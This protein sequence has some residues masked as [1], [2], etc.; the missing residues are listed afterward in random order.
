[1]LS[2]ASLALHVRTEGLTAEDV[3]GARIRDRSIVLTW[4]MRGT[5][6]LITAEDHGWLV[7]IVTEPS[8][9]N[10][11]RRLEQEGVAGD[12]PAK[13]MRLIERML[14]R[15]GPL[16]R[17]EIAD[18]LRR[19]RIQTE[20][21]AI[22]HLVWLASAHGVICHATDGGREG[23][24]ALVRDWLGEPKPLQ[25]DAAVA[26]LA[27]RYL[28][29]HGPA[30]PPD[31][32]FWSGIRLGDARRAWQSIGDRLLEVQTTRGTRWAL[33]SGGAQAPPRLVRLLPSFD[34]Y[35]LGWR[36][37]EP[38]VSGPNWRQI[39]RGGGW[40]YPVILVDGRAAGT[41]RLRRSPD[42]VRVELHPFSRLATEVRR[43]AGKE[44][45][46]L[47]RFLRTPRR[48][49]GSSGRSGARPN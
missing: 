31:L 38:V 9:A 25:R 48:R 32:A 30:E 1:V 15:D 24:F 39:N 23:R 28:S 3:D 22:A 45:A 27:V 5:L 34:E 43:A 42:T 4:A 41:W 16:T 13:A 35:L 36:D 47:N 21:Q 10:A 17:G 20:G 19:Q 12:Q 18:R 33:R 44:E 2:G 26:E 14:E 29:A 7:P 40:L 6:H 11:H 49:R 8:I 46:Y 37:R